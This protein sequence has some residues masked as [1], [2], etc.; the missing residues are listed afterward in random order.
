MSYGPVFIA[1]IG[2]AL[3][4][5]HPIEKALGGAVTAEHLQQL[6]EHGFRNVAIGGPDEG[7][8]TLAR[9]AVEQVLASG[10]DRPSQ[11]DAVIYTTCSYWSDRVGPRQRPGSALSDRVTEQLLRPLGL[12]T[13][14][15]RVV[16]LA[17]SG[18]WVSAIRIARNWMAV[19]GLRRIVV[20]TADAVPDRPNEYRAMPNSVTINS[21]G[22]AAVLLCTEGGVF[23]LEGC[24]QVTSSRMLGYVKGQGLQKYL[25]IIGG[26]RAATDRLLAEAGTTADDYERLVTNNYSAQTLHGF[27]DATG[28][29]RQRL[30]TDNVPK[31]AHAFSADV[32]INLADCDASGALSP[33]QRV[34]GLST[35]PMTWGAVSL[36][37]C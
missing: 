35:G 5:F 13:A 15:L 17:E 12:S 8:V 11:V 9:R 18:N 36:R 2:Y 27:A 4:R 19:R 33:G 23:Q 34:L 16:Y 21:D 14:Q 37:R 10:V 28:I 24:R 6:R 30:F 32:A 1:A 29:G 20:V 25:E 22:A 26:I 31:F 7:P 3:G